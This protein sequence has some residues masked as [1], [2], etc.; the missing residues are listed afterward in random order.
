MALMR[1]TVAQAQLFLC[2]IFMCISQPLHTRLKAQTTDRRTCCVHCVGCLKCTTC[3]GHKW[4]KQKMVWLHKKG[5]ATL[6]FLHKSLLHSG[7][8][9]APEVTCCYEL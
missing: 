3:I 7:S 5:V 1:M 2:A 9:S 8:V 6:N 4:A